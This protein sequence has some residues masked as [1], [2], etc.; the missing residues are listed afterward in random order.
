MWKKCEVPCA[1]PTRPMV[2]AS[3]PHGA[4]REALGVVMLMGRMV[5]TITS[6]G[7]R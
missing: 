5:G 1:K 6:A 2:W 4:A 3:G 7:L